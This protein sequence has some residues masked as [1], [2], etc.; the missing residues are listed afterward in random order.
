MLSTTHETGVRIPLK[1]GMLTCEITWTAEWGGYEGRCCTALE[2]HSLWI[3]SM[4]FDRDSA[5]DILGDAGLA[6]L[7][8]ARWADLAA[9]LQ[10]AV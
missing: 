2:L 7:E 5:R 1:T 10:E 8:R 6:E 9:D 4:E 3:G